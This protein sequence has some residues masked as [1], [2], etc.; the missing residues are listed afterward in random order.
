MVA[1]W[2]AAGEAATIRPRVP[3]RMRDFID[4]LF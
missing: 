4:S 1:D 3:K 2:D